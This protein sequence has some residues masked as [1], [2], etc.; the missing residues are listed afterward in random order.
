MNSNNKNEEPH[1][2]IRLNLKKKRKYNLNEEEE[3]NKIE[4]NKIDSL[5]SELKKQS[6]K[7]KKIIKSHIKYN[8]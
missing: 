3:K 2:F 7:I 6:S 1:N 8:R 5:L 4:N